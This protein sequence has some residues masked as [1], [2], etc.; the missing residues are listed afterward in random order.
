MPYLTSV[1]HRFSRAADWTADHSPERFC[2]F[3]H[4]VPRPHLDEA[5]RI[6]RRHG[7]ATIHLTDHTHD[8]NHRARTTPSEP[9]PGYWDDIVSRIGTGVSE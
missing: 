8:R 5:L 6:A 2:H 4:G 9:L 1:D 3:V 7:A